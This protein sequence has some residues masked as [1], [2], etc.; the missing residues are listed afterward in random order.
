MDKNWKILS[1]SLDMNSVKALAAKAKVSQLYAVL[2]LNRGIT[3]QNYEEFLKSSSDNFYN[4]FLLKDM[5]KAVDRIKKAIDK[6]EKIVIYGDYDVDGITSVAMLLRYIRSLGGICAAYIPKREDEGYGLNCKAIE[7]IKKGGSSLIVTVDNGISAINEAVYAK[8]IGIDMVICDHHTCGDT[9][10]EAIACVNPKRYDCEYPF[11]ELSGAGVTFKLL[12]ALSGNTQE[13]KEKYIEYAAIATVADVVSLQDENRSIVIEGMKKLQEQDIPWFDA[14]S[15][16]SGLE[17]ENLSSYHIG[18]VISPRLNAAGRIKTAYEALWL[19]MEDDFEKAYKRA[20]QLNRDNEYRKS[21]GNN[22]YDEACELIEKEGKAGRKVIVL[23]KEG[24]HPGVIGIIAS[25]ISDTY[26]KNVFLLS[27]E[28][29]EAKGSGRGIEGLNLYDSL[30]H[31]D[32]LLTKYGGH[33][34]AAGVS[35]PKKNIE[36][37]EKRINE[38]ADSVIEG[39]ITGSINID[40]RLSCEG[41]LLKL[42]DGIQK[43]EPFGTDNEKPV[44]AVFGARVRLFKKTKDGKHMMLKFEKNGKEFSAIAFG[45]GDYTDNMRIGDIISIAARLEKNE[46]MGHVIPQFHVL[47]IKW[48]VQK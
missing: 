20:E 19:I 39:E 15:M 34:L 31:C 47:D 48:E 7:K 14:L 17:K 44:F 4:P 18:F 16:V 42:C 5:D 11:K 33:A 12:C 45:L 30:N 36:E 29:D 41:S 32:T 38:Y 3:E 23:A 46:Y 1:D 28:G 9:I 21:L 2:L 6:R 27:I 26:G 37:F 25:K 24:W 35:L 40:C 10:P 22:I 43:L 8:E 13:I